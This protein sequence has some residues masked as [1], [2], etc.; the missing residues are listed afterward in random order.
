MNWEAMGAVGEVVG[1]LA[2]VLT[3]AYLARQIRQ[4]NRQDLLSAFRHN[5][6]STNQFLASTFDSPEL[7][8]LVVRGR[9]SYEAL[10]PAERIRFDHFHFVVLNIVESNLFQVRQTADGVERSYADWA[11]E[12]MKVVVA[13]YFAFP[14]TR[15]L[16]AHLEPYYDPSVRRFVAETLE[17]T[18]VLDAGGQTDGE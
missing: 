6:D 17:A 1:A 8:E 14:G 16:W 7:A 18:P 4:S 5:F 12:N 2:V 15:T 10:S 3:L 9:G 13:G 11:R